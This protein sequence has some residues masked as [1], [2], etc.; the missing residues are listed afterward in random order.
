MKFPD[1]KILCWL[2]TRGLCK[3]G[4]NCKF[5]HLKNKASKA[6]LKKRDEYEK[7]PI[8]DG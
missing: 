3:E 2:H 4:K 1:G 5:S 6:M 7:V 8:R